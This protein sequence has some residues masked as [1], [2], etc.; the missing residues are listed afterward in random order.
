M[1]QASNRSGDAEFVKFV[2]EFRA[3]CAAE[4]TRLLLERLPSLVA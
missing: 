1:R 4:D 2:A 3:W